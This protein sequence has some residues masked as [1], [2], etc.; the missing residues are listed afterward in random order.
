MTR[1]HSDRPTPVQSRI[2]LRAV[3]HREYRQSLIGIRG[4]ALFLALG[5][6]AIL[7]ANVSGQAPQYEQLQVEDLIDQNLQ[8][9]Q[10]EARGYAVARDISAIPANR[11]A[12]V[13]RYFSQYV[14]AKITQLDS[15]HMIN[16]VMDHVRS[17]MSSALRSQTPGSGN[18][19][20]WL[21]SGLKPV[22]T[23]NYHPA[24]RINAI[25]FISRLS[26]PSAQRGGAPQPYAFVLK[27]MMDIYG[28]QTNPDAVRAAALQ[29]IERFVRYTPDTDAA[30]QA[31]K[32]QLTQE[33]TQLLQSEAPAGRDPLAHAFLQ[34]YAVNILTNLSTDASIGKELVN[35]SINEDKPNLIALHSAAAIAKLP[36]KMNA[37]DVE[38]KKVLQEWSKRIL[39]S[40]E[41]EIT[42][43]EELEKNTNAPKV[44]QPAEPA[45]FLKATEDPAEKKAAAGRAGMGMGYEDMTE[46]YDM[47][48]GMMEMMTE[49]MEGMAGMMSGGYSSGYSAGSRAQVADQPA[50]VVASR[51]KLN[52]VI[53]QVLIG[54]IGD[55]KVVED[56]QS[57]TP[58]AGLIASAPADS[59]QESKDWLQAM[60]DLTTQLNDRTVGTRRDYLKNLKEQVESLTALSEGKAVQPKAANDVPS[61]FNG[62]GAPPAGAPAEADEAGPALEEGLEGLLN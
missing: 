29:G 49:N 56:A 58:T 1:P 37:A 17:A 48:G 22:A 6:I 52:Y 11:V 18:V 53:Q 24:A 5:C 38:T 35:L 23:G 43:L 62:F 54:L 21:Y 40:F 25:Q 51:R 8:A 26:K 30:I 55:A 7:A 41:S 12:V 20:R 13:Q 47:E 59:V 60:F 27:D 10:R 39:Q 32:A 31:T 50:E 57:I 61:I 15:Q 33:M 46:A 44:K 14:P 36:G 2:A 9:V 42:R 34:R 4:L 3:S 45:T 16:D 19:M 28:A